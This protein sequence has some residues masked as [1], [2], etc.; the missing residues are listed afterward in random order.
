MT[1]NEERQQAAANYSAFKVIGDN[2]L[3][4][5]EWADKTMI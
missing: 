1:R 5:A 3:D 4:G 2:F